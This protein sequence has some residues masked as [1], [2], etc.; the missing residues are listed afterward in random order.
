MLIPVVLTYIRKKKLI[1]AFFFFI[2]AC[3][4]DVIDGFIARKCNMQSRLGTWL[5]PLADKL[6]ALC[7]LLAFT[8]L[9]IFPPIVPIII[10]SKEMIM[11]I[12]GAIAIKNGH[13]VPS[14]IVGK[15]AAFMLNTCIA[16]G[17]LHEY[18]YPYY[19]WATYV[20]LGFVLVAFV[21]YAIKYGHCCFEKAPGS[22]EAE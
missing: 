15:I 22:R 6:M 18:L 20:T 17:F 19:I 9:H 5:D 10:F 7:V 3:I 8:R 11:L 2:A 16:S 13:T 14:N 4:T 21:N 1:V 12:C